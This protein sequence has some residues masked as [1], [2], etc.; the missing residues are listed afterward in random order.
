[1]GEYRNSQNV[2]CFTPDST[3]DTLYV[4]A[5]GPIELDELIDRADRH[6]DRNLQPADIQIEV[7][8]IQTECLGYDQYDPHDYTNF[9]V[10]TLAEEN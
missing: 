9:L 1:M 10:I 8:H 5:T 6:F 7:E 3:E 4:D 2:R